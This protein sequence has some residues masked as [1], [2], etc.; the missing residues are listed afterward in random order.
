M[1]VT[2]GLP[3]LIE[4]IDARKK[5]STPLMEAYLDKDHNN[6]KD[7]RIVAEKIKE[8]KLIEIISE[9]KI[10]FSGKRLRSFWIKKD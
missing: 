7:S 6:E 4:I 2:Q 1:Q 10:D 8:I 3:R 5:P 9:I